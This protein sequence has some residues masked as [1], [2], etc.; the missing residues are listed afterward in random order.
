MDKEFKKVAVEI[1]EIF[2]NLTIDVLNK[3]PLKIQ[4]FFKENAS[5]TYIFSYD[6]QKSLNEQNIKDRT[7]GVI[8]VLYR[9]YICD[10]DERKEFMDVYS[11]FNRK[12]EQEKKEK[13]NVDELFKN[14]QKDVKKNSVKKE[15][16]FE[17]VKYKKVKW[18]QKIFDKIL[19]ILKK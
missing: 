8:A 13:Y 15:N 16:E 11:D 18:Y 5:D 9:D 17:I 1:N 2:N 10:E 12:A 14:K 3:I 7:R 19:S 6:K 4:K